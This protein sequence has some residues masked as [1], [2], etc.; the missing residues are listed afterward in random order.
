MRNATKGEKNKIVKKCQEFIMKK[1][2]QTMKRKLLKN[3]MEITKLRGQNG[4]HTQV[5]NSLNSIIREIL[6]IFR[7]Y[8][9]DLIIWLSLFR[10][11]LH[12]LPYSRNQIE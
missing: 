8:L 4:K 11:A 12:Y 7:N 10:E 5:N 2:I 9:C 1:T 3:K 6:I